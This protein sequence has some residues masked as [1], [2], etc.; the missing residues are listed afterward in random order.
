[1]KPTKLLFAAATLLAAVAWAAEKPQ[2]KVRREVHLRNLPLQRDE[3]VAGLV[4]NIADGY[5][6]A[7]ALPQDWR[8]EV[9]WPTTHDGTWITAEAGHGTAFMDSGES[10]GALAT[11]SCDADWAPTNRCTGRPTITGHLVV[12]TATTCRTNAL[13][14]EC[15]EVREAN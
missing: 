8:A 5:V 4:I 14:A 10:F 13:P 2:P 3:R 11:I 12:E 15:F 7:I 1:M 6:R 9:S